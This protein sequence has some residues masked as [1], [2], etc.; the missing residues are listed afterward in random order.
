MAYTD[1]VIAV[2]DALQLV[3]A[4]LSDRRI[5]KEAGLNPGW[6]AEFRMRGRG[7]LECAQKII[8]TARRLRPEGTTGDTLSTLLG[9]YDKLVGCPA[10]ASDAA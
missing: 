10:N 6:I 4:T 2:I 1:H 5:S 8:A 7:N 9:R 3:D